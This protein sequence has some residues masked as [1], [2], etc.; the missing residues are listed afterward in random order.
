MPI[1][2]L[3]LLPLIAAALAIGPAGLD[4]EIAL[5]LRLPRV[6]AALAA[7]AALALSGVGM[8]A[9]LRN[10]L[11]DP[12]I[13]GMAG[14]ASLGA[15]LSVVGGV[16]LPP[17][18]AGA[19][20]ALAAAIVVSALAND[21]AGASPE[22]L[23]LAGVAVSVVLGAATTLLLQVAP[24]AQAARAALYWTSGG[25]GAAGLAGGVAL[26]VTTLGATLVARRFAPDL[27]RLLL[28][29]D[30]A[31][32]LGVD[33]PRA[34]WALLA[35]AAALT[36]GVVA[37]AGPLGFVGLIAPHLAR[38]LGARTHAHLVPTAVVLGAGLLL[39]ADTSGRALAGDREIAA[40]TVTALIG[41][42]WFLWLLR[43]GE[44]TSAPDEASA[45]ATDVSV[46]APRADAGVGP[47]RAR[48]SDSV[49]PRRAGPAA[50]E[51]AAAL[52]AP[53]APQVDD[54]PAH[55]L[56][57][58]RVTVH[59]DRPAT[60]PLLD[61]VGLTVPVGTTLA[62]VGP[63][64]AGKSTLLRVLAG[65]RAPDAGTVTLDGQPLPPPRARRIAMLFQ[66]HPV[67]PGLTA[68]DVVALGG[69]H[70]EEAL[71]LAFG[72]SAT[73]L[74]DTRM[75]RLSGGERQR[76]HLARCL[77]AR[78]DVLLL[79]EPTNHLDLEGRARL[80]AI[81]PT[82][83]AVVATHDLDFAGAAD[84]AVLLDRGRVVAAGPAAEVLVPASL[85]PLFGVT[86]RRV[87]DPAGGA[88]L[89]RVLAHAPTG[90]P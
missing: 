48:P 60:R 23:L 29:D 89:T 20:G 8:Q 30:T 43:R 73:R 83:T 74:A 62:L 28:G 68:R 46:R 53:R 35:G 55:G 4:P 51:R 36:G 50:P 61:A 14:G 3:P 71:A 57:A 32:T 15:V 17:A 39:L 69:P 67:P 88:P 33:V 70:V 80:L 45:V 19:L 76:A 37:L 11:A 24:Q 7:G 64:G 52:Q 21:R 59:P 5:R 86:L 41:G 38:R 85:A 26:A 84:L 75:S 2:F 42:P 27:D 12:W 81:L 78:P 1:R 47:L 44:H 82:V 9:V 77:A 10:P 79:D 90:V 18:L 58:H 56:I 63:N 25:L 54:L 72:G 6:V 16:P 13:L 65:L 31:A 66:D 87:V 40:G 34:R 22:R 49:G